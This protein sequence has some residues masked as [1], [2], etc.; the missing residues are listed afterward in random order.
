LSH[1]G[2]CCGITHGALTP[3]DVVKTRIQLDSKSYNQGMIGGFKQIIAREGFNGLLTGFGP[4]AVGYFIQGW[5]KFG[6]VE[7]FKVTTSQYL[8]TKKAWEYR[9]SIYLASAAAAEFIADLFLCPL[10]ATRIRL[11]SKPSYAS[12]LISAFPKIIKEEG[13][14]AEKIYFTLG[15]NPDQMTSNQNFLISVF[16]GIFAGIAADYNYKKISAIVSHPA[17]TLLSLINKSSTAGGSG[18]TTT[19]LL[20]LAKE[21]GFKK[22]CLTGL[23]ARCVMVGALTAS[24][25]GIFDLAITTLG[26]EKYHFIDP[27]KKDH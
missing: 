7:Y 24:Q 9:F 17:D 27:N 15:K 6:G 19:R 18:S 13:T 10:E 16:S 4:T 20:N 26:T 11:V 22:L 3:V 25:F 21:V 14:T 1:V 23:G 12:G 5:F 2:I 8:G